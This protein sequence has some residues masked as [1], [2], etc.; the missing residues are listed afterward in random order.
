MTRIIVR[1]LVWDSWTV[2]HMKKHMLVTDEVRE[3]VSRFLV[4]KHGYRGR[5][6]LIG[7]SGAR[8]L[9]VIVTREFR[10]VYRI[11]TARDADRKERKKLYEKEGKNNSRF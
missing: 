9:S 5:Y 7:R 4:H 11:I 3:A 6:I 8:I 2:E 1:K 10:A